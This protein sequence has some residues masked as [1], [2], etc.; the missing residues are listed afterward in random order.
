MIY[1][2]NDFILSIDFN[3][4]QIHTLQVTIL[5]FSISNNQI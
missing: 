3:M 4:K 2:N 1:D 5:N